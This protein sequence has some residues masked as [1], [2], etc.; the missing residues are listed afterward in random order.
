MQPGPW[1]IVSLDVPDSRQAL[2]IADQ[3]DPAHCRLKIGKELFVAAGPPLLER[4]QERNYRIFLDLKFHDIPT[5]VARACTA[6]ARLG[7][8]MLNVHASGGRSMLLAAREAVSRVFS[9]GGDPP[10]LVAVTVL[11]SM[12]DADLHELGVAAKVPEQVARLSAL[13]QECG[14]D[15]VVCSPHEVAALRR[16]R[17]TD[18]CLVTPGIRPQGVQHDDQKRVMGPFQALRAGSDYLVIGRPITA[19]PDPMRALQMI[20]NEIRTVVGR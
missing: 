18:F 2:A 4:L 10:L 1:I 20:E 15:G 12:R 17:G 8:W 5:T 16:A 11:T 6:A 3:L 9:G 7:V 13:A 19:A 14:I